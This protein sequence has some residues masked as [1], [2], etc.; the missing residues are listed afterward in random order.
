[1]S[2]SHQ[3]DKSEMDESL[4]EPALLDCETSSPV[5]APDIEGVSRRPI[6]GRK[7]DVIL[8]AAGVNPYSPLVQPQASHTQNPPTTMTDNRPD[9]LLAL[10]AYQPGQNLQEWLIEL[11]L[12]LADV[13]PTNHTRYLLR[14]LP[15]PIRKLALTAG[16]KINTPFP[17]ATAL[18][19]TLFDNQLSP[20]T[21]NQCFAKLRQTRNQSVDDFVRE[22]GRLESLAFPTLPQVDRDELILH[23]FVTGLLYR[24]TTKIFVLHPPPCLAAAIRQCKR[25][26]DF[27]THAD[28][29]NIHSQASNT[30]L[31]VPARQ[32]RQLPVRFPNYHPGCQY[33]AAFGSRARRCGHNSNCKS[34][35]VIPSCATRYIKTRTY[36]YGS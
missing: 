4:T 28:V 23:H 34:R 35:Y 33:W 11:S 16:I 13:P 7:K 10:D 21:A 26:D 1:M 36:R 18:L 5:S 2:E 3:Q 12:F 8:V 32:T 19:S 24:T 15:P 27:R 30:L 29:Q 9:P 17:T 25:Y 20:G 22:L 31:N 14:F 6:D